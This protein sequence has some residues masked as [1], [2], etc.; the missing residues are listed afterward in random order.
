MAEK[1]AVV[2]PK[3][4]DWVKTHP[5]VSYFVFTFAI[6]WGGALAVITPK[7]L[8]GESI[9]KFTGLMLFPVLLL[10][11]LIAG[12]GMAAYVDGRR[13]LKGLFGRAGKVRVMAKWYAV[14]FI[15]PVLVLS[16]LTLLRTFMSSSFAPNRF[17]A[18]MGF[19]VIA[20]FV[21]ELGWTGFAFPTMAKKTTALW[22]AIT[23][24]LLWSIWHIP[25]IDYL[26]TATP[27][28][29]H[30]LSYFLCFTAAMTAMRVLICWAYLNTGSVL[31]AQ[32][33][34]MISTGSLV[35]LGPARVT[36]AEEALWYGAYG[37]AL[38]L[39][40]AIVVSIYGRNLTGTPAHA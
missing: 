26:G 3:R 22:A 28:G 18:G 1:T 24:G 36:A 25:V 39:V 35:V 34:H 11:P 31:L 5:A 27:H 19:G 29:S 4:H 20:G 2:A 37:L 16:V 32:L 13:G 30:W 9:P 12:V 38:W 40:V 33:M 10:G 15:P 21:E 14:L 17:L 6:S 23:L 7:L 8:R